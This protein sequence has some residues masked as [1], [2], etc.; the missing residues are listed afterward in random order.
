MSP[1]AMGI[2]NLRDNLTNPQRTYMWEFQCV[3]P[4]GG[5]DGET[6]LLRCQTM[7]W[8]GE[9]FGKIHIPY[10]QT[11]GLEVPGKRAYSHTLDTTMV[12]GEDGVVHDIIHAWMQLVVDNKTGVGAGD[13]AIKTDIYLRLISTKGEQT[14]RIR[15][16]GCWPQD[17]GD[18]PLSY[19]DEGNI[20]FP[21]SW[22]YDRWE[23]VA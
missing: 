19:D 8:P 12:E 6:L 15:M 13:S 11:A 2:D 7:A 18:I 1:S 4:I 9:S 17:R 20:L 23:E 5:G 22:N 3:N 14:K 10:K 21:V 16:T